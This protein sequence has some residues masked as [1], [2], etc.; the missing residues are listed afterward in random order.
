MDHGA[1][2]GGLA[3]PLRASERGAKLVLRFG[4]PEP[5]IKKLTSL[6]LSASVDGVAL[7]VET[8]T[9]AGECVYS[10]SVPP[11]A[12]AKRLVTVSFTLDKYLPPSAADRRE[13]G[14]VVTAVGFEAQ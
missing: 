4:I 12:L 6:K 5:V 10:R 2:L 1:F 11:Q 9:K 8:Y 3:P 14:V 13:L 7:P